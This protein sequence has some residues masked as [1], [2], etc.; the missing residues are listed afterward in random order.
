MIKS[1]RLSLTLSVE[2]PLWPYGVELVVALPDDGGMLDV[3]RLARGWRG[4]FLQDSLH[5]HRF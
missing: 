1:E 2:I 5:P 3:S 4:F